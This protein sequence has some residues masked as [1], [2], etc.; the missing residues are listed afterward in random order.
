MFLS[1]I[2]LIIFIRLCELQDCIDWIY[3]AIGCEVGSVILG[4]W[5]FYIINEALSITSLQAF[6]AFAQLGLMILVTI[7]DMTTKYLE[8]MK[9]KILNDSSL[10]S[11]QGFCKGK[12]TFLSKLT[13]WWL[14]PLLWNGFFEPLELNDLGNL[15]EKETSRF[16]YDQ[17]LFI[18]SKYCGSILPEDHRMV[19]Y[20]SWKLTEF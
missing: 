15:P 17:F 20:N 13:F 6:I 5:K 8:P 18:F 9:V 3:V 10:D 4:I 12:S 16:H 7:I 11:N 2:A 14:M 19:N 1:L